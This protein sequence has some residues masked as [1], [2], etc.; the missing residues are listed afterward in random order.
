MSSV[1]L[2]A[3]RALSDL[4]VPAVSYPASSRSLCTCFSAAAVCPCRME[5]FLG[6]LHLFLSSLDLELRV[7]QVRLR[8]SGRPIFS[9]LLSPFVRGEVCSRCCSRAPGRRTPPLSSS[10]PPILQPDVSPGSPSS[11]SVL[12]QQWA[13]CALVEVCWQC[14][15]SRQLRP[16]SGVRLAVLRTASSPCSWGSFLAA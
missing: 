6:A 16:A 9:I 7:L 4:P 15:R 10:S 13:Q 2:S 12:S 5:L 1:G 8:A 3:R 14:G 11:V